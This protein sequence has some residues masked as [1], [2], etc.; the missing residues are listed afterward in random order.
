MNMN[1][2]I[3]AAAI[4]Y[5]IFPFQAAL[6]G[7]EMARP[8]RDEMT[9]EI[10]IYTFSDSVT[11][12]TPMDFPYTGTKSWLGFGC[13]RENDEWAFIGFSSLNLISQPIRDYSVYIFIFRVKF[14]DEVINMKMEESRN[15][16]FLFFRDSTEAIRRF[17][18]H[19]MVKLELD[20]FGQGKVYFEYS[21]EGASD[22]IR[23]AREMCRQ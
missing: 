5:M 9:G 12:T 6:A 18:R 1:R 3:K 2:I 4:L 14:D 19:T 23:R 20:W 7:W 13:D 17:I 16:D 8:S 21:L 22:A 10:R 11:S 15:S